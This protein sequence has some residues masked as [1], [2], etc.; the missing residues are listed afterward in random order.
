MNEKDLQRLAE[1]ADEYEFI[2]NSI[3]PAGLALLEKYRR[4]HQPWW[5]RVWK[6]MRGLRR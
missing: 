5:V 6:W 1:L 2:R 3:A 4:V